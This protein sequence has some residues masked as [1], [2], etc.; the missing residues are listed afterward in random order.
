MQRWGVF[1]SAYQ[2][3]VQYKKSNE[4]G[5]ADG[6]SRLPLPHQLDQEES[7]EVFRVSFVDALPVTAAE[8][9]S[10][11]AKDPVLSQVYQYVMEG[12]P[13]QEVKEE[14]RQLYQRREQLATDQGC[15]LWGM[16][17]VVP[18]KLARGN[19]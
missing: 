18:T 11:T 4:H 19:H 16:R 10:E 12:W 5:N 6:L 9:A 2:Y 1:L 8:I 7:R 14:L 3:D 17:V 13:H 15:L